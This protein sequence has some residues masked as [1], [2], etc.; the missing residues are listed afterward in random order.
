MGEEE[1]LAD[2][3]IDGREYDDGELPGPSAERRAR[4]WR[5]NK[6]DRDEMM[7]IHD[8]DQMDPSKLSVRTVPVH[9]QSQPGYHQIILAQTQKPDYKDWFEPKPLAGWYVHH[10][11]GTLIL[12]FK[13]YKSSGWRPWTI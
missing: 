1:Y 8:P 2:P 13:K 12:N 11:L 9:W 10:L 7:G 4:R 3:W 6:M 5:E